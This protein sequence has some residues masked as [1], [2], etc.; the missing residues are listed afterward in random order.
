[1][2]CNAVVVIPACAAGG[3]RGGRYVARYVD[4]DRYADRYETGGRGEHYAVSERGGGK[5]S[6]L[7]LWNEHE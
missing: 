3:G 2:S 5:S 6:L 4:A 7:I 1:M